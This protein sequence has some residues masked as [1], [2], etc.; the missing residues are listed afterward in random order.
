MGIAGINRNHVAWNSGTVES[1]ANFA[2]SPPGAWV[3][4]SLDLHNLCSFNKGGAANSGCRLVSTPFGVGVTPS[5][6]P[7]ANDYITLSTDVSGAG[8]IGTRD[9][10]VMVHFTLD[11]Y[12]SNGSAINTLF[13]YGTSGFNSNSCFYTDSSNKLY[14]GIVEGYPGACVTA[15]ALQLGVPHTAVGAR[16]GSTVYQWVDGFQVAATSTA[17]DLAESNSGSIVVL[18]DSVGG[19]FRTWNGTLFAAA[20][21]QGTLAF[22]VAHSLS[23]NPW[24]LFKQAR[25]RHALIPTVAAANAP[26]YLDPLMFG[27]G[28]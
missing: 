14:F 21:S 4:T 9:H 1:H 22:D 11:G 26:D 18:Q 8:N 19:A 17:G 15:A 10:W 25:R 3:F 2:K 5:A 28:L 7:G 16:I 20:I 12:F 27:A 24:Q 13:G 23:I 6:G